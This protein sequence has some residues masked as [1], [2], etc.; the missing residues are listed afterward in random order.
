MLK[1]RVGIIG[2][3][4][5]AVIMAE[6]LNKMRG[7]T[8]YAIASRSLE[9]AQA[10]AFQNKIEKAYGSY[11][12]MLK[13]KNVDLVYI[14]TPHSHH[15]EH[16]KLCVDYGKPVLVEKAFCVN[17]SQAKELLDYAKKKNVFITEAI[18]VRYMP[19][20][21]TMKEVMESGIIGQPKLLTANLGYAIEDKERL[22]DPNLAGGALL[23]VGIYPLNFSYMLFGDAVEEIEAKA[24]LTGNGVDEQ[25]SITLRYRDGR[26]AVL[27]SSMC[28]CSDRL[29]VV[30]GTKGYMII[31]NINNYQSLTVYNDEYKKILSKK[32]PKQITGYEYEI[33]ACKEALKKKQ[34]SCPQMPHE[35]TLKMMHVMDEIRRQI[36]VI[37]PFERENC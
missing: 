34:L 22:V 15:L 5:I 23:D 11:E 9:K 37:Y 26:M 19:M 20:Y 18:W 21:Q 2:A 36:G 27:N 30:Q 16:A 3:G 24:V 1:M 35:E 12:E 33:L 28:A 7:V 10:F 32:C 8:A 13:D 4:R 31:E 25:D 6:T 29:G 17:E 14:A